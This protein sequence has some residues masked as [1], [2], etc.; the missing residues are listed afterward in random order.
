[1]SRGLLWKTGTLTVSP[2]LL[3]PHPATIS[4]AS[5]RG[6]KLSFDQRLLIR[7]PRITLTQ[8]SSRWDVVFTPLLGLGTTPRKSRRGMVGEGE[9]AKAGE[10]KGVAASLGRRTGVRLWGGGVEASA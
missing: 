7:T 4:I 10:A 9:E 3:N 1:M 8:R 2:A 5:T 6:R